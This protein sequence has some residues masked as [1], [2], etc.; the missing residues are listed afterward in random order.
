MLFPQ[1]ERVNSE[2]HCDPITN[3][4][5]TDDVLDYHCYSNT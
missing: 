2:K 1:T 3:L 4:L 5:E